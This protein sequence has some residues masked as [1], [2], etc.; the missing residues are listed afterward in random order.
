M[1]STQ[2]YSDL[3]RSAQDK[4]GPGFTGFHR[5][6]TRFSQERVSGS[7]SG[8]QDRFQDW[9]QVKPGVFDVVLGAFLV[10]FGG[11]TRLEALISLSRSNPFFPQGDLRTGKPRK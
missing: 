11:V 7:A 10:V 2:I 9:F 6:F 3:L 5:V 4:K 8:F 1:L